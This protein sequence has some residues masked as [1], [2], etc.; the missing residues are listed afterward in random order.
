LCCL[1][2]PREEVVRGGFLFPFPRGLFQ[3]FSKFF[4]SETI[5][6]RI[7]I[8]LFLW[9]RDGCYIQSMSLR[10][11]PSV[12]H[13]EPPHRL[14]FHH[15]L[16]LELSLFLCRLAHFISRSFKSPG[17]PCLLGRCFISAMSHPP[18]PAHCAYWWHR[19]PLPSRFA[20][21]IVFPFKFQLFF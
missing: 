6:L 13:R 9:S 14:P 20:H 11:L 8:Q 3:I 18:F 10:H 19:R 12:H 1:Q 21:P 16:F 7:F 5:L 4:P 15:G 17:D 2:N